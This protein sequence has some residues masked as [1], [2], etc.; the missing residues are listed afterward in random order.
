MVVDVPADPF[1][2]H[3]EQAILEAEIEMLEHAIARLTARNDQLLADLRSM[4]A[5]NAYLRT[6]EP[7]DTV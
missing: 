1:L 7:G 3:E 4:Q 2:P 5:A 6:I